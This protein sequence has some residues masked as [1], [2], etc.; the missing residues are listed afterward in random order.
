MS[1]RRP[2]SPDLRRNGLHVRT[3][4]RALLSGCS[5]ISIGR[6]HVRDA[7]HSDRTPG[8]RQLTQGIT[9]SGEPAAFSGLL[10]GHGERP[11]I[12][13]GD[14]VATR[15]ELAEASNRAA[16]LLSGLGLRRG[17]VVAL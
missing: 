12:Y 10:D 11:A 2:L 16:T 4:H 6:R 15:K 14:Y 17:D 8:S 9:M 1:R 7:A 3:P 5:R 13:L